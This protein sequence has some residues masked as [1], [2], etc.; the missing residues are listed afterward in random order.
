[1]SA[2]VPEDAPVH[3]RV[4][5]A[6]DGEL[7]PWARASKER[8]AHMSRVAELM[9]R[10][11]KKLG[12]SDRE[13]R[14]WRA[15]AYLHDCLKEEDGRELARWVSPPLHD[16]PEPLLHGPAAAARLEAEG[17]DDR[18]LLDVLRYHTLGHECFGRFGR[19]LFDADFLEPGRELKQKWRSH[20]RGRMPAE[21][22]AVTR[23]ILQ[24]RVIYLVEACRPV[25]PETM[26]FWNSMAGGDPWARASEV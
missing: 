17:V 19:A 24:G 21:L 6:S 22:D 1:V 12:L 5:A 2:R 10:W 14:R 16:L 25:R 9:D 11:A 4:Q 8:V 15:V 3:P 23:E 13:R 7:P 26:G 18:E 20:L